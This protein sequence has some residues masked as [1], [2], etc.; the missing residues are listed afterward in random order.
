MR[1]PQTGRR[2]LGTKEQKSRRGRERER[3]AVS[4]RCRLHC[5]CAREGGRAEGGLL[6]LVSPLFSHQSRVEKD[7]RATCETLIKSC[8]RCILFHYLLRHN[9]FRLGACRAFL[10]CLH[11]MQPDRKEARKSHRILCC[12]VNSNHSVL[13]ESHRPRPTLPRRFERGHLVHGCRTNDLP[14][15]IPSSILLFSLWHCMASRTFQCDFFQIE[16]PI[17]SLRLPFCNGKVDDSRY[18]LIFPDIACIT[19]GDRAG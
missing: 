18:A 13:C 15:R 4:L 9:Y 10:A 7:A 2:H 14:L 17:V 3:E 6:S 5:F 11:G 19:S 1:K 8:S 16:W 12:H